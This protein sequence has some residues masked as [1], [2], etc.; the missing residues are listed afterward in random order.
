M[1]STSFFD[2]ITIEDFKT[3]FSIRKAFAFNTT[4]LWDDQ[5]TYNINAKVHSSLFDIYTSL[6]ENNTEPLT[7][8]TAW[9]LQFSSFTVFDE[10]IQEAFNEA[11]SKISNW[12]NK[13]AN[14]DARKKQAYLLLS[15]HCLQLLL[16]QREA[17]ESTNAYTSGGFI[18]SE[19]ANGVSLSYARP[20]NFTE[21]TAWLTST[22]FGIE[23]SAINKQAVDYSPIAIRPYNAFSNN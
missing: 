15:A 21:I 14:T 22:P 7:D 13:L 5:I 9:E 1:A 4:P 23:Y 18:A 17:I 11:K 2:T 16:Q 12:I 19:S 10:F 20:D 6:I 3:Y 8:A